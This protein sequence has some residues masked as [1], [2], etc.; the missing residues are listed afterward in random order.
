MISGVDAD[1]QEVQI[2]ARINGPEP[3]YVAT[4][5]FVAES[6]LRLLDRTVRYCVQSDPVLRL[7]AWLLTC[8][9]L[10]GHVYVCGCFDTRNSIW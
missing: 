3:G 7:I 9:D 5:I 4:P 8:F 10:T 6:A 2:K 1:G